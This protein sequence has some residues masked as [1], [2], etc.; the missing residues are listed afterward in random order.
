MSHR[1]V[2]GEALE[3]AIS[4]ARVCN[5][6]GMLDSLDYPGRKCS[7]TADAQRARD[8]YLQVFDR[9]AAEKLARERVLQAHT[10]R[11]GHERGVLRKACCSHCGEG[12]GV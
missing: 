10:V 4:A 7:T 6:Q 12:S 1:F 9:I 11:F 5:E 2:A 8:A 3:E